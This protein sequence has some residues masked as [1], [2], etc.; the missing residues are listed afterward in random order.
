MTSGSSLGPSTP[1]FQLLLSF[2]PSLL[3]SPFASLCLPS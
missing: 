2:A 3:F 1:Q